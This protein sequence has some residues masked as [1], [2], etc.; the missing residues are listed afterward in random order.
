[1]SVLCRPLIAMSLLLALPG[2]VQ[3]QSFPAKPVR[4]VVPFPAGGSTDTLARIVGQ[5]LSQ[6][7]GQ[8]IV[9]DNKPGG[10]T[11][12]GGAIVAKAPADGYTLLIVANSLV[13]QRQAA[14]Q[15]ALPRPQ[16]F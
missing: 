5:H 9:I 4:I 8:S 12:I 13:D 6:R 3:A 1:M 10:G 2:W 11:V 14:R 7:W 15:P 16:G